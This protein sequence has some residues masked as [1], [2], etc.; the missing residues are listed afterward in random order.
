MECINEKTYYIKCEKQSKLKKKWKYCDS[1]TIEILKEKFILKY[2]RFLVW[3]IVQ[4]SNYIFSD[5]KSTQ[6][7]KI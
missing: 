5:V 1:N 3:S 7:I 4:M 2:Q 6:K